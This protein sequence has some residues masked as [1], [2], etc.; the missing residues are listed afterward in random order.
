MFRFKKLREILKSKKAH[1]P[2]P[3]NKEE[4]TPYDKRHNRK[5]PHGKFHGKRWEPQ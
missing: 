5:V 3:A 4:P 1:R 2:N